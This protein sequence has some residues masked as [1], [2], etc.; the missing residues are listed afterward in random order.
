MPYRCI[1]H[2]R[3]RRHTP[4]FT[5]THRHAPP[6]PAP[7]VFVQ[8]T[9][10]PVWTVRRAQEK[11]QQQL[12]ADK[13]RLYAEKDRLYFDW[14][15]AQ[16]EVSRLRTASPRG[17]RAIGGSVGSDDVSC[18]ELAL[19]EYEETR[20]ATGPPCYRLL[21]RYRDERVS[22][23]LSVEY[24]ASDAQ[25]RRHIVRGDAASGLAVNQDGVPLNESAQVQRTQRT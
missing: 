20:R 12:A 10:K 17:L 19:C 6:L 24:L 8:S 13:D 5:A 14:Q 21:P 15:L 18:S 22:A 2:T 16:R 23:G 11:D 7:Q 4:L 9:L 3:F 25:R 1:R